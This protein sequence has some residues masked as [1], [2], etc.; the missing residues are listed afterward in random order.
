MANINLLPWREER[1]KERQRQFVVAL[2]G[3][4]VFSGLMVLYAHMFMNGMIEDQTARNGFL[5]QE[6]VQLDKRIKEIK[7]LEREK[8]RLLARMRIIQEL[9]ANRPIVVHLFEELVRTL[10][11]GTYL[12]NVARK[13]QRVT[14]KGVAESNARV[15]TLMNNL[16]ASGWMG[17]SKLDVI[18]SD[19]K[20]DS[21]ENRFTLDVQQ[22]RI[23][24]AGEGSAK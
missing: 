7:D 24:Q 21:R 10:P 9:Q 6:I 14:L 18:Q 20:S 15:S 22:Q 11:D 17:G 5:E 13:D 19:Q 3:S 8:A 23:A 1:R 12:T 4:V 2:L 16:D